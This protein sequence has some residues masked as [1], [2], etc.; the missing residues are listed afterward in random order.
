MAEKMKVMAIT[1]AEA[2]EVIEVERPVPKDDEV[3]VKID[4]CA[5]CTWEQRVYATGKYKMPFLGGHEVTGHIVEIGPKAD[6]TEL[7]VGDQVVVSVIHSCG[8]CYYCRRGEENLCINAYKNL[9]EDIGMNG[10]GGFSEYKSVLPRM[11]YKLNPENPWYYGVFAEPLAC[12]VNMINKADIKLG[13]DVVVIGGGTMGLL[14]LMCAKL[15][16]ARVIVS[17]PLADRRT[18][19]EELGCDVAFSPLECDAVEKVKS[20]TEGRG[21]DVVLNTTS[22]LSV[23]KQAFEMTGKMGRCLIYSKV[24]PNEAMEVFPSDIHQTEKQLIGIVDPNAR[25]FDTAVR[26]LNKH[27]VNPEKLLQAMYP[28]EEGKKA[29]DLATRPDSFRV[30]VTF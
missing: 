24:I 17:E 25:S 23:C 18:L 7:Q 14:T 1:G 28:C 5:I 12:I 6:T 13:E 2:V 4:G 26:L 11:V 16:G 22:L 15:R 29:F 30:V 3:L 8:S 27:L 20:L 19:A 10:P 9:S 21:A